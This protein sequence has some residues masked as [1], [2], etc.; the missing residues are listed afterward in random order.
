VNE[1]ITTRTITIAPVLK[2]L[3][4]KAPQAHAFEVFTSGVGRWW[5]LTH[6]I[7]GA[8]VK[9][10][11]METH[12]GGRWYQLCEDGSQAVIGKVL[13]WEP[14]HR[15]VATWDINSQWKADTVIGSEVEVRFI[16]DGPDATLV[17][18]EHRKF[19]QM[20]AEAGGKMRKDVDGGWP[21][22]LEHFRHEAEA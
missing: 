18:L 16:P 12:L 17:E 22:V 11:V 7:G 1:A 9:A 13:V 3:R 21:A 14:P 4:V 8:P 5:P 10:V 19:E 2:S 15:F 6:S 20:G